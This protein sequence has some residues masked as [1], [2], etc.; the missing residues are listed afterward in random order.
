MQIQTIDEKHFR[1]GESK[2]SHSS[3]GGF[4]PDSYG[5]NLAY[6]KGQLNFVGGLTDV[7][8]NILVGKIIAKAKD[9][10]YLGNDQYFLDDEGNFYTL[11]SSTLA[12]EQT[13]STKT[14]QIGTTDML[15][16]QGNLY[17]TSQNDVTKLSGS[18]LTAIDA[19]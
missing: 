4:S 19:T 17:V 9:K 6:E 15:Q 12:K 10:S 11:N 7:G 3:D 13:D 16:F 5:L 18:G 2:T 14:Y 8:G 1:L